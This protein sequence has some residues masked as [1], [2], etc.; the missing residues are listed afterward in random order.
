MRSGKAVKDT[1][2]TDT[3]TPPDYKVGELFWL[4]LDQPDSAFKYYCSAARDT[5]HRETIPKALYSAA[6][7]ARYALADSLKADSLYPPAYRQVSGE[8]VFAKSAGGQGR[9]G[10]DHDPPGLSA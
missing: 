3:V 6:W 1:V 10:H 5:L 7:I 2:K 8:R 9:S 4:E